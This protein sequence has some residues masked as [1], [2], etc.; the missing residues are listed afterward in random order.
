MNPRQVELITGCN[1]SVFLRM[2]SYLSG[3]TIPEYIRRRKISEAAYELQK[4]NVKVIDVAVKYGYET[5]D[6]FCVAFKKQHGITPSEARKKNI[7]FN[8]Y[9]RLTFYLNITGGKAMNF[10]VAEKEE[11]KVVGIYGDVSKGIWDQVKEDGTLEELELYGDNDISLG[12]CFG[13][14]EEGKNKYMVAVVG[15]KNVSYEKKYD[16]YL[17]PK[18]SWLVFESIGPVFPTLQDMWKRIYGEFIP[19][20]NYKQNPGI[21]T[22]EKYFGNDTNSADYKVEIWIPVLE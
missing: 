22:V 20:N 10:S 8:V 14:D 12:L 18:S 1:Y 15:F 2:F 7:S 4:S 6:A 19:S 13:Y 3:V 11:I 17:I 16:T 5:A 9:P 21:P